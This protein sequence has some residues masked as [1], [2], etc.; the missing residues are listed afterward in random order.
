MVFK[1]TP[2]V[3]DTAVGYEGGHVDNPTYE[4][5][6]TGTTGH[7]EVARVEFD[8]EVVSYGELVEKFW[9]IHDPTQV[10]RQGVDVGSQYRSVIFFQDPEQERIARESIEERAPRRRPRRAPESRT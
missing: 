10:D 6:C 5:V 3:V 9:E 7:A 2:G 1:E 4:Q 8:P